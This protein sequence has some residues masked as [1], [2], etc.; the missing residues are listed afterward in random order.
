[1]FGENADFDLP[2]FSNQGDAEICEVIDKL[3]AARKISAERD[4]DV[5]GGIAKSYQTISQ[6]VH[7][8]KIG[9]GEDFGAG[10]SLENEGAGNTGLAAGMADIRLL[11]KSRDGVGT[12]HRRQSNIKKECC[13]IY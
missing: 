7:A 3:A 9:I 12:G 1:L 5:S 4:F 10:G 2:G 8:R 13:Q 6:K 11:V